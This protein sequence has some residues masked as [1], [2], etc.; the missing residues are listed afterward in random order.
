MTL[1]LLYAY[2]LTGQPSY[3]AQA[4]DEF[5]YF[6]SGWDTTS[7]GPCPGGVFWAQFWPTTKYDLERAQCGGRFAYLP[8]YP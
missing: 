8:S 2:R 6:V 3:L 4:E 7:S 1:D 5:K